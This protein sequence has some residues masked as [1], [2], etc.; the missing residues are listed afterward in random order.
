MF[1]NIGMYIFGGLMQTAALFHP[2]ARLWCRGRK[3]L[4]KKTAAAIDP[5]RPV[6]W[7]HAA[8]LG[9][10]EQGRQLIEDMRADYPGHQ[11]VVTFFSPSGYEVRKNYDKADLVTYLPL[12]TPR[13]AKRFVRTLHPEMV[14]FIKYEYWNNITR[15]IKRNGG[16]L[17]IISAIYREKSVFFRWYGS[18]YRKIL[19][20]FDHLF[21]QNESSRE[22]LATI[23]IDNVTVCGD[24]RFDRV[25]TIASGAR[26]IEALKRF[27]GGRKSIVAG[28]TW[29]K[30]DEILLKLIVNHGEEP[31][32][33]VPHEIEESKIVRL[34][35]AAEASGRKVVRYTRITDP[36][37]TEEASV[38]IVDTV[39]ILSSVY[40]YGKIAYIG[41]GFGVGIHNILEAATFGLPVIFGPNYR[42]FQEACDLLKLHGAHSISSYTEAEACLSQLLSDSEEL[43]AETET[44]QAYIRQHTGATRTISEYIASHRN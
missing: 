39:G 24:T 13:N 25:H 20:R 18:M 4:L 38:M 1:Y 23:G 31:F 21:V 8:S 7:F 14:I 11:I 34:K 16:K 2:K 36:Q 9:E 15:E 3:G 10:F 26:E 44:A 12:D 6:I 28:S 29:P 41:G 30:D 17:Y 35:E 32:I 27:A 5:A 22:L 40:R 43:K 33:I 19:K 42:K 37:Q